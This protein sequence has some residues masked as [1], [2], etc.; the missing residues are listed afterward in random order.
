MKAKKIFDIKTRYTFE[1]PLKQAAANM[2]ESAN[3]DL[4]NISL[5]L[6]KL[7]APN[8]DSTFLV[9]VVGESMIDANIFEGDILIVDKSEMPRD[10]KIVIAALNGEM[11]VKRYRIVDGEVYLYSENK[12]FLP[13]KILQF[14]DFQIQGVVKYVIHNY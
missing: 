12:K 11:A 6:N 3:D 4:P 13:I 9:R 5:N 10:G 7:L 8:P 14:M 2:G 1:A